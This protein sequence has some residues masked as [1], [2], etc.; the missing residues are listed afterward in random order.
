[1]QLFT[2]S[3][4]GKPPV[5]LHLMGVACLRPVSD[6][7]LHAL[8]R[9]QALIQGLAPQDREFDLGHVQPTAMLGC[10]VKLQPAQHAPRLFRR[11]SLIQGSRR[12]RIQVVQDHPDQRRIRKMHIDQRLHGLG[13]ILLGASLGHLDMPPSQVGFQKQNLLKST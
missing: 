4:S 12:M 11:K 13:K 5:D 2:S 6:D 3:S 7:R 8:H 9:G 1:M 10:R